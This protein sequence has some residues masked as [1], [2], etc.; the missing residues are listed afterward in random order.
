METKFTKGPWNRAEASHIIWKDD[1]EIARVK[2]YAPDDDRSKEDEA[3]AA[4]MTASP[5]LYQA[6]EFFVHYCRPNQMNFIS[7]A[8]WKEAVDALAQAR[9]DNKE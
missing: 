6:L 3:N 2:I 5:L 4:L 9:G 8:K 1:T 7:E